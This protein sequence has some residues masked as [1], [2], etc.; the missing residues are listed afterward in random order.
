MTKKQKKKLKDNPHQWQCQKCGSVEL[1]DIGA[2]MLL[3]ERQ[4]LEECFRE[5]VEQLGW[6]NQN[7]QVCAST[8][9]ILKRALKLSKQLKRA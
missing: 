6:V 8:N 3:E 2:V 4:E 9:V 7:I 5:V 1:H